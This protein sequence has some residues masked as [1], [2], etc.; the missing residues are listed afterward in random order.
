MNN[1]G[2]G[3]GGSTFGL[4]LL[5]ACGLNGCGNDDDT[6]TAGASPGGT[7][8]VGGSQSAN[9]PAGGTSSGA[10]NA[11][12]GGS[13]SGAGGTST[14]AGNTSGEGSGERSDPCRGIALPAD[15]HYVAPGLCASAVALGQQGLRQITFAENGDLIG[16]RTS[17]EIV[18]F[19]DLDDDGMF[20]GADE[21]RAIAN[22]GGNGNNAHLDE[23]AGFLYAGSDAGVVRFAYSADE[24]DLGAPEPVVVNQPSDGSHPYHTVHVYDGMLYVHSG[25]ANNAVAPAA[26]DVDTNRAVLKRF[27]LSQLSP[28]TPFD[29]SAGEAVVSGI[30]NMVGFT[31]DA[32]GRMFGVVN[33][34][35]NLSYDGQDIHLNNPGED[36]IS[37]EP[38]ASH[39]YPYCFTAQRVEGGSGMVAPGTQLASTVTGLDNPHDDAWCAQNANEPVSFLPAHSAPLDIAF[40]AARVAGALPDTFQGGAFI[41]Q[42]GSWNTEPS[43]GHAVLFLPFGNGEPTMPQS[44]ATPP[45]FPFS[46]VF[47]GGNADAPADGEWGWQVGDSGED[48]VRPVGVAIS[49][50]DGALYVSSD[51]QG[52]LYRIG[53][54]L[55]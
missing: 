39:G 23:A 11:S 28:G 54:P 42:H 29:W 21:I 19:R 55:E 37:I 30:R 6:T 27:D 22:T 43:V 4:A 7:R 13:S 14:G 20:Q 12:V 51:G 41:T 32:Q 31:R 53:R 52:A 26:P 17:G 34:I 16:V 44:E 10:G 36:V 2:R 46:V 45:E 35:D 3:A 49:P 38:G 5:V 33:G 24:D 50:R 9:P 47:G 8:A 48:P 1:L 25:S 18:R 15:Q 40:Y